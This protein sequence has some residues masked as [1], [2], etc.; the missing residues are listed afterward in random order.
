MKY[1]LTAIGNAQCRTGN[2]DDWFSGV[3]TEERKRALQACRRC[4]VR[5][6]CAIEGLN[7]EYGI[8]GGMTEEQRF[9]LR[10]LMRR[11]GKP[12]TD[13]LVN[14]EGGEL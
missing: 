12:V 3:G 13:L 4:A 11:T 8:W 2:P 6:E 1:E 5:V 14:F 10:R 7:H 9:V